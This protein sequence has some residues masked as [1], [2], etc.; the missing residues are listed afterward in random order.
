VKADTPTG[1]TEMTNTWNDTPLTRSAT[2]ALPVLIDALPLLHGF[3][4]PKASRIADRI[5]ELL[6][7]IIE[8]AGDVQ[9][10]GNTWR[11]GGMGGIAARAWEA[12]REYDEI[13]AA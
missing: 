8:C 4:A 1:E 13:T 9:A 11:G 10:Y 5:A 2:A 12:T 7:Q 6:E 3:A